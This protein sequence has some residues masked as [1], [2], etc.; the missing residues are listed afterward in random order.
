MKIYY[1]FFQVV[2][3]FLCILEDYIFSCNFKL[4]KENLEIEKNK[5]TLV[6][7]LLAQGLHT[8]SRPS[9][10]FGQAGLC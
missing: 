4:E 2:S 8:T 9:N 10:D 6:G 5:G 1:V 3:H 7:G